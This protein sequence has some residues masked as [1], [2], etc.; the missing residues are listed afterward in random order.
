[1]NHDYHDQELI[2]NVSTWG[3]P[4]HLIGA[5]GVNNLVGPMLAKMG[6]TEIHVWDDD[7]LE[8]RNCPAEVAYSYRMVGQPK[9]DAMADVIH[10]LMGDDFS[11][12]KHFERVT[13]DTALSGVVICGVDSMCSRQEIWRCVEYNFIHIPLFI[14]G[15]SAGEDVNIFAFCPHDFDAAEAYREDWLF[16]DSEASQLACGARNIAYI[17]GYMATEITN[18]ITRFHRQLPF[19]FCYRPNFLDTNIHS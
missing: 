12:I 1:M 10:Y 19:E 6:I 13:A 18:I 2:F 3:W 7:V 11:I 14:D 4:V 5:G 15:R 16:D 8:E 17:A 9:V